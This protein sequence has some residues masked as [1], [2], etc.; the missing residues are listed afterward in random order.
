MEIVI[1]KTKDLRPSPFIKSMYGA[2]SLSRTDDLSLYNLITTNGIKEPLIVSENN[3]IISGYR[4]HFIALMITLEEVPVIVQNV[5]VV[6]EL[7]IIEHNNHRVKN[8]VQLAYEYE[9]IREYFGSKQG[10]KLPIEQKEKFNELIDKI[11]ENLSDTSRKRVISAVKLVKKLKPSI[12]ETEA[13]KQIS[14]EVKIGKSV[15]SILDKLESE[16]AREANK[17]SEDEF[18]DIDSKDFKIINEDTRIAYKEIEDGSIQCL[19]TSPPYFSYRQYSDSEKETS[20]YPIG[21]EPTLDEY[22]EQLGDIFGNY[23][24]KISRD[25]SIFINLMDKVVK[26]RQLCIV[27]EFKRYLK[28][29]GF[30]FIQDIIWFKKNP[31]FSGNNK[32]SQNSRE[33]I[34]HFIPSENTD[35]YWDSDFLNE[36]NLNLINNAL[37]G[38]ENKK[39]LLRNVIIPPSDQ[40]T[41][42]LTDYTGGLIDADVFSRH[43][44]NDLLENEGFKLTHNA[45]YNYE[46]PMMFILLSSKKNDT[47]LDIFSGLGST[48]IVAYASKRGYIGVEFSKEYAV[49]SKARFKAMFLKKNKDD[50]LIED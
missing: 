48:G 41:Q 46:I 38:G 40:R 45:L 47:C 6:S 2:F 12:S 49:Q 44:L 31:A 9:R 7:M 36:N 14:D 16:Y 22:V 5:S 20:K 15:N 11:G 23:K 33:Y 30:D 13:W 35:Y 21:E 37:Y 34:L 8:V 29:R 3:E 28:N 1:K 26:G 32:M 42:E 18:I 10:V 17:K 27:D 24:P 25:G 43:Y 39:K 4:R 50:V 19:M